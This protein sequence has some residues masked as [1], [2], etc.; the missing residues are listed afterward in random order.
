MPPLG[1]GRWL[2]SLVAA[3]VAA[4]A[5]AGL[6]PCAW[7]QGATAAPA[8]GIRVTGAPAAG[9]VLP[10]GLAAVPKAAGSAGGAAAAAKSAA[11][12]LLLAA[13]SAGV[14]LL[15]L[16]PIGAPGRRTAPPPTLG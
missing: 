1:R 2:R 3:A 9:K 15:L 14:V 7:C 13:K 12:V 6:T 11:V 5:A 8:A 16:A 10:M 4:A